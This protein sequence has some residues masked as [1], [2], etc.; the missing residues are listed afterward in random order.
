MPQDDKWFTARYLAKCNMDRQVELIR[1]NDSDNE[2]FNEGD[3]YLL[4]HIFIESR[5]HNCGW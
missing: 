2:Q 4:P 3:Y 1:D 5:Q